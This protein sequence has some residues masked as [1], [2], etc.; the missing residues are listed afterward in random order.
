MV[1]APVDFAR[2]FPL[3]GLGSAASFAGLACCAV[4]AIRRRFSIWYDM[5]LP[6][7]KQ[8]LMPLDSFRGFAALWV[9][10]LH[11]VIYANVFTSVG[12]GL[13]FVL[14]GHYGVQIFVVLSG[15]LI[16]RSLRNLETIEHLRS[17]FVRR[18]L[19]VYPALRVHHRWAAALFSPTL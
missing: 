9:A 5:P 11:C 7:T 17:Y 14:L 3:M 18:F 13:P 6:S 10:V 16:Y 1:T 15:M 12:G 8:H 19:R 2:S 4:P